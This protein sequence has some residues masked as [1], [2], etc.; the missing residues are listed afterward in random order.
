M[1]YLPIDP[2][3]LGRDYEAV[4]RVNSQSGKGGIA[5][6]LEQDYGLKLPKRLQANFSRTVQ[7]LA[8]E[9]SREL[10]SADI[11]EAFRQRYH[12]DGNGRYS[13]IDYDERSTGGERIFVGKVTGPDGA[14]SV[15][16]RGNGLISSVVDAVSTALGVT[17]EIIDYNEH[18]LG[19]GKD[20]QAAAY[21]ECRTDDGKE[22][23]GVGINSDVATASVE[24][25][26]SAV[27]R[28]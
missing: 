5:W 8:D 26:L 7:E 4:I 27:N 6:I 20:A 12:L 9:T 13:L 21:I 23:Y 19:S 14:I 10:S 17:L 18:A 1:P 16:G 28:I 25:I 22:F 11:W 3:D 15:S 24:A 2:R